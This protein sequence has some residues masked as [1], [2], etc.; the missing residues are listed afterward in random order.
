MIDKKRQNKQIENMSY[1]RKMLISG[2]RSV[3]TIGQIILYFSKSYLP[4]PFVTCSQHYIYI[5]SKLNNFS[6]LT[7]IYTYILHSHI[8]TRDPFC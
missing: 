2:F 5:Y 6:A 4:T 8:V 7:H 1:L 3:N